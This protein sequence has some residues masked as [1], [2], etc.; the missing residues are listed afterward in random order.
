MKPEFINL[1]IDENQFFDHERTNFKK[2]KLLPLPFLGAVY[3]M[4]NGTNMRLDAKEMKKRT[5][6]SPLKFK[7]INTLYRRLRKY[8]ITPLSFIKNEFAVYIV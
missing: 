6:F 4:V 5:K 2:G 8:L 1:M 7:S 3:S